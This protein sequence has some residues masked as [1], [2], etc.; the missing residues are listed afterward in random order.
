MSKK[1]KLMIYKIKPD[2][3]TLELK[4]MIKEFSCLKMNNKTKYLSIN[5]IKKSCKIV[6]MKQDKR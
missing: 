3:L 5:K 2:K 1:I 4:I 6:K